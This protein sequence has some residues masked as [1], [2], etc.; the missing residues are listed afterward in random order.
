[1]IKN[2]QLLVLYN[3]LR[4]R[5]LDVLVKLKLSSSRELLI[6]SHIP[7]FSTT[8]QQPE[9]KLFQIFPLLSFPHA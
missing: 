5:F 3:I 7:P 2:A 4:L 9:N 8:I 1:M 6:H